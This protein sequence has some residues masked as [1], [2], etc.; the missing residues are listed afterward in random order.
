LETEA[1]IKQ[2]ELAQGKSKEDAT[3]ILNHKKALDFIIDDPEY[4]K[5][6]SLN[7]AIDIH[8]LLTS[9]LGLNNNIRK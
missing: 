2:Q 3:M 6:L 5:P 4:L 1:F 9:G 7:K 8:T